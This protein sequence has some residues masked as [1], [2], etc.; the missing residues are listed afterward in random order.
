VEEATRTHVGPA[1]SFRS[2]DAGRFA[3]HAVGCAT[4]ALVA[5]PLLNTP[6]TVDLSAWY[7]WRTVA[8]AAIVIGLSVWGFRNVLG[9]QSAF[10]SI[11]DD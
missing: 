3:R 4:C 10:G 9:T 2:V 1:P 8:V 5:S 11:A 7:A 6:L